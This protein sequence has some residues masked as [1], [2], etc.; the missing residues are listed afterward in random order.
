MLKNNSKH[1]KRVG[2]ELTAGFQFL[3]DS[4]I[5]KVAF[6]H[7]FRVTKPS[8]MGVSDWAGGSAFWKWC[9]S[10][11]ESS[12]WLCYLT[13]KVLGRAGPLSR[14]RGILDGMAWHIL[15]EGAGWYQ[16]LEEMPG[17]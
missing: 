5:A 4:G 9:W 8:Q 10:P 13:R 1:E 2:M 11:G 16:G 17:K 12:P 3:S 15:L 14:D 6:S 7:L